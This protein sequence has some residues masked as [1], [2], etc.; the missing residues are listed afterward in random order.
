MF[1]L[2]GLEPAPQ[3]CD[4]DEHFD[5]AFTLL[6][7]IVSLQIVKLWTSLGSGGKDIYTED[8]LDLLKDAFLETKNEWLTSVFGE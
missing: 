7:E 8:E 2:S 3:I 1:Q 6:S 5:Q 4:D